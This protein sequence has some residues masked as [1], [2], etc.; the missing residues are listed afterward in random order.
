MALAAKHDLKVIEDCAQAHGAKYR[1]RSVGSIGQV[2]AWSFCQDKIMTTAGEGEMVTTDDRS[3]WS[4]KWSLKDH[5]P[6]LRC[7]GRGPHTGQQPSVESLIRGLRKRSRSQ[8]CRFVCR[9]RSVV[10]GVRVSG[11]GDQCS[12]GTVP[13]PRSGA[14][15]PATSGSLLRSYPSSR[16]R[17]LAA[18]ARMTTDRNTV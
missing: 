5:R 12:C 16:L 18:L 14:A 11:M 2:G 8:A 7:V 1:G 10:S 3:V 6:E 15:G 17:R 9:I 13:A 4:R